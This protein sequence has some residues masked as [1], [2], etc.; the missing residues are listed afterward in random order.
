MLFSTK[1]RR[2]IIGI[3]IGAT[4]I[5]VL[6]LRKSGGAIVVERY[7]FEPLAPGLIVDHKIKDIEQVANSLQRAIK[8]SG[9]KARR[10]AI[11]ITAHNVMSKVVS[12]ATDLR[13]DEL[14]SLVEIEAERIAHHG[15]D[16]VNIDYIH[17]G[18]SAKSPGQDDIQIVVCRKDVIEDLVVVLEEASM[19]PAV[20][21]V[22][23]LTLGRV[24]GLIRQTTVEA[25]AKRTSALIDFGS[26]SSRFMV[27][28]NNQIIY[29]RETPFGGH[30]LINSINQKYG[31]PHDEGLISLRK[32]DLPASFKSDVLKPFVKTLIQEILRS[33]QFF[34]SSSTYN[35]IDDLM[36]TGGCAH[37]GNIDKVIEK[38]VE[39]PTAIMNP[40]AATRIGAKIDQDKFRKAIPSLAIASGLAMRGLE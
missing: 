17:L 7:A 10:A 39:V 9:S 5:K 11:C 31:T 34:Y 33:L 20:V 15:L 22:D 12:F 25:D 26:N 23:T 3:D 6:E 16:E 8:R 18:K 36:I 4:A 29:T 27:F 40:F 2:K 1:K 24:H 19:E 28:H 30:Q 37:I 35:K 14:E 38:R 21:D 13:D 32:G